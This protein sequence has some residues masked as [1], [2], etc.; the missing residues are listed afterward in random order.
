MLT[1]LRGVAAAVLLASTGC[2][3]SARVAPPPLGQ[4]TASGLWYAV[5]GRGEPVL[6]LHGSNLDSRSFDA[7]ADRLALHH[8]VIVT[9]LRFHGRS[10][11]GTG[12]VS[13]I[14]DAAEVLDAAATTRAVL[15]GHSLG[16]Q[17]AMDFALAHPGRVT[18]LIMLGPW[19]SGYSATARP[20]GMEALVAAI[21]ANDSVAEGRALAAM[22]TFHLMRDSVGQPVVDRIVAENTRLFRVDRS[23]VKVPVRPAIGQL[24]SL[25]LPVLLLVGEADPTEAAAVARLVAARV[26]GAR[27]VQL[28]TCGHLAPLDCP[29]DVTRAIYSFFGSSQ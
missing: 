11:D 16:A 8:R 4:R 18:R 10:G 14:D 15:I 1:N 2:R 29:D 21:G 5:R 19:I 24:E 6:L 3:A 13:F 7:L 27:V 25:R 17:I 12:P 20:A 9:D 22:P 28:P 23:R 26:P